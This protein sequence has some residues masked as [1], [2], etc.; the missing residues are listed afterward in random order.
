MSSETRNSH[1]YNISRNIEKLSN[2]PLITTRYLNS[3]FVTLH[4]TQWL[5]FFNL[6]PLQQQQSHYHLLKK[7]I[8]NPAK[9]TPTLWFENSIKTNISQNF[10]RDH[11]IHSLTSFTNHLRSSHSAIPSPVWA[12]GTSTIPALVP[13]S[14]EAWLEN[15]HK[16]TFLH[17]ILIYK[18]PDSHLTNYSKTKQLT[19]KL[20]NMKES[21]TL[22]ELFG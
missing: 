1:L 6:I 18:K 21:L 13:T 7:T 3:R 12:K 10:V 22:I 9:S 4:F 14:T 2:F 11:F 15:K 5:K 8:L 19:N 17:S 16:P 20:H